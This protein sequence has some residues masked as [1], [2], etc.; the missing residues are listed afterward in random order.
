MQEWM[1]TTGDE[2]FCFSALEE[3]SVSFFGPFF[4]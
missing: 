4:S 3:C 2:G 1:Q